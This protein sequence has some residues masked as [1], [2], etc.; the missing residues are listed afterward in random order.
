MLY[1]SL[2]FKINK[3]IFSI[4]ILGLI[5]RLIFIFTFADYIEPKTW[6]YGDIAHNIASGNGF[7]RINEFSNALEQTSSHAPLYP[8][9][10]ALFYKRIPAS[11][12]NILVLMIQALV[13][14]LSIIVFYKIAYIVF[15]RY[16][17]VFTGFGMALYLPLIY[18]AGKFTPTVF[19]VFLIGAG[20]LS[21]LYITKHD[22]IKGFVSGIALGL[23][24]L[25]SPLAIA[26]IIPGLIYLLMQKLT[27]WKT[28]CIMLGMVILIILPW[29]VRNYNVHHCIVPI[30]TQF[31]KNFWIGNNPKA[32]GTDY[33]KVL[34]HDNGDFILMTST[35][36]QETSDKLAQM[37]EHARSVFFMKKGITFMQN[38]PGRFL[39]LLAKKCVYFWWFTPAE[40]NGSIQAI[41]H[42]TLNM[43][44]YVPLLLLGL[45]GF[46]LALHKHQKHSGLFVLIIIALSSIYIITHVGLIRYRIPIETIFIIFASHVISSLF[47]R[48]PSAYSKSDPC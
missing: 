44:V 32:T 31:G 33:Y 5:L 19:F 42:R 36:D 15:D 40:I 4:C 18:Y 24:L 12:Q 46:I 48:M 23:A 9:F 2:V 47:K 26:V 21:M 6:E 25:C 43:I 16:A 20:I 37:N 35:L 28:I 34:T 41:K 17:A 10:L 13:S 3:L 1:T 30:T 39:T 45:T 11:A 22:Y 27:H 38:Y 7:S 29:T 14:A 8:F